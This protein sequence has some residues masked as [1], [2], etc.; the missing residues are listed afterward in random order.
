MANLRLIYSTLLN[1]FLNFVY[2]ERSSMLNLLS[3]RVSN[4][5]I[6]QHLESHR[7]KRLD[8]VMWVGGLLTFVFL[9]ESI[10]KTFVTKTGAPVRILSNA[11]MLALFMAFKVCRLMTT[12]TRLDE[13]IIV[14][15]FAVPMILSIVANTNSLP[16]VLL[17]PDIDSYRSNFQ[18]QFFS[19]AIL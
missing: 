5:Q 2:G 18:R 16:D 12:S 17:G 8:R 3:L 9:I 1:K 11:I 13:Y 10:I 14:I 19:V 15:I 6:A 7:A 4:K